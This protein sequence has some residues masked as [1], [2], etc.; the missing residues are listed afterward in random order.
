LLISLKCVVTEVIMFSIVAFKTLDISQGSVATHLRCGGIFS[1]SLITHFFL[2]LVKKPDGSYRFCVDYRIPA[3]KH[4]RRLRPLTRRKMVYHH[5]LLS[6]YWQLGMTDRAKEASALC[7]RQGLFHFTRMP[8]GL[9]GSPSTFC[10]AMGIVLRD[11]LWQICLCY[12]DDIIVY[13]RTTQELL[14]RLDIVLSRLKSN[15]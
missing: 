5:Y 4:P 11:L 14:E 9:K 8:F 13:A 15:N 1:E 12:L 6:G 10:R 7:T 2:I 3:A